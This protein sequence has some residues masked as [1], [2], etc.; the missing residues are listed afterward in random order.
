MKLAYLDCASGISG[1]MMLGALVDAGIDLAIL[2]DA[3]DSLGLRGVRLVAEEVRKKGFRATQVRVDYQPEHVHRHLDDILAL[4]DA[5]QISP[6]ARELARQ[7]FTRLA[8]AEAKVHGTTIQEVHF[9]EVGAADS[10]ADIVGT[11]VG[12]DLLGVDQIMASAVPTGTGRIRIAHGECSIPAPAT[13]E[14]LQGIPLAQSSVAQELTTPTGAAIL[15]T[16]VATFGPLPSMR[17]SRI[18]CGAGQRDLDEQPNLLRLFLGETLQDQSEEQVWIVETNLDDISGELIGYATTRLWEAGALDVYLT[19]IQMKKNRPAVKLTV[20]CHASQLEALETI[21]FGETTTLGI[22]RWPVSRQVLARQPHRVQTE[23][24]PVEGK[25]GWL[26]DKS[27]RFTPEFESC[28]AMAVMH[29][30]PLRMVYEAAQKV[31][32]PSALEKQT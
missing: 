11:A 12:W 22:R 14:L 18:G 5:S 20:L 17:I 29:R 13:A 2:N 6:K 24:G 15:A 31:F 23:W 7:I 9:H 28:R 16:L 30:L 10:I 1:D 19:P 26:A 25:V 27:P 8:E 3:I 4:I 32:D 21:L